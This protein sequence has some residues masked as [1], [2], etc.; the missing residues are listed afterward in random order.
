MVRIEKKVAAVT[1]S[2][3][4]RFAARVR[5]ILELR[6]GV[7]ILITS[8]WR[9][10]A[11]NLRFRKKPQPTDVLSFPS[12]ESGWAG[13]IAISAEIA[14]EN[15]RRLG[16]SA[17]AEIKTLLLHGMLHLAGYDHQRDNGEMARKEQE[18]RR[19]LVLP[20]GLIER[21]NGAHGRRRIRFGEKKHHAGQSPPVKGKS[22][23][24]MSPV[25]LRDIS[26]SRPTPLDALR[27]LST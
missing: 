24:H 1:P 27:I 9:M 5:K 23:D 22:R 20:V 16:H 8:N 26:T 10:R 7:N 18:L 2:S 13:E 15:A 11:L 19:A 21:A 4:S 14:V 6:G 3:L 25:N 12:V 17:A